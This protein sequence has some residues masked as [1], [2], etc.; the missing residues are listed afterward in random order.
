M[1]TFEYILSTYPNHKDI[2]EKIIEADVLR[3]EMK[4]INDA[5]KAFLI[6][7]DVWCDV[8]SCFT[9]KRCFPL[10]PY[11]SDRLC[12]CYLNGIGVAK[13]YA[14]AV[15]HFM[16]YVHFVDAL[17]RMC[18]TIGVP[19]DPN[20]KLL[21]SNIDTLLL[22][23]NNELQEQGFII[24]LYSNGVRIFSK[25]RLPFEIDVKK[26][27]NYN[28]F[29]CAI[30]NMLIWMPK[31]H[32]KEIF[33]ARYGTLDTKNTF[34]DI[35][36]ALF[37]NFGFQKEKIEYK[38]ARGLTFSRISLKELK[39]LYDK[40][41]TPKEFCHCYEYFADFAPTVTNYRERLIAQ[42]D[43]QPFADIKASK[44][45]LDYWKA[46]R[47]IADEIEINDSIDTKNSFSLYLEIEKPK[48]KELYLVG[49]LKPLLDGI[50][51]ALHGGEFDV[52][53]TQLFSE[54]L[55]VPR[56]WITN[57]TLNVLG[58]RKY[59]QQYPSKTGIKWNPADDL[60]DKVCISIVEGEEWRISGRIYEIVPCCPKCG[61][62]KVSIILYGLPAYSEEM[63]KDIDE[64]RIFLAGCMVED[65]IPKYI[66]RWCKTKF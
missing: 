52:Q 29:K 39:K 53:E 22:S 38:V 56:E 10:I 54:K 37:Y 16:E 57:T 3:N 5:E 17:P 40:E 61:K 33:H 55:D 19:E 9:E 58:M 31:I 36:N 2:I 64:G 14:Q 47:Q 20:Y 12:E 44:G 41:N 48:A 28:T 23:L 32:K 43:S 66:C 8:A 25:F 7:K 4:E 60:C 49:S 6:C 63:Q 46:M 15:Y 21:K 24:R 13:D 51:S 50:I 34:C 26:N 65:S 45:V 1:I 35:E 42:W 30:S 11:I 59:I 62:S 18:Q 27:P